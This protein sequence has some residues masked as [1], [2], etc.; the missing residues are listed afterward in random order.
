MAD[1]DLL[2]AL[3]QAVGAEHVLTAVEDRL[4]HS[5]DATFRD[6]LPDLVVS[7]GST[8]EV[9]AV[10]R[11]AAAHRVPLTPRGAASGLSGGAVPLHGGIA[12]SLT[13]L[14]RILAIDVA[15]RRAVV[16][17]GVVTA[18]QAA[19]AWEAGLFYPPDPASAR[20]STVGGNVAECAGGPRGLKYGVTRDYVLALEV[21]LPDGT[22]AEV[23]DPLDGEGC[24]PDWAMLLVGSEGT[25]GIVTRITLRLVGRP[26]A[27]RTA[28]AIFDRLDDAAAAVS[29][30]IAAGV[31]P[32]TLE[33]MDGATLRAVE[34]YL[35]AG[36]PT[37]AEAALLVELDGT[38]G[39][40]EAQ[41]RQ[42][43]EAFRRQGARDVQVAG[44]PADVERLWRARRAI[45]A[46]CGQLNPTKI[47]EDATVPRSRVPAL[48]REVG[49]I[50]RR[51]GV[52]MVVFGHAGDGNLHP[53]VL[54]NRDDPAEMER[55]EAAIGDLFA[56]ALALGGTLSG[57][58]G[59]GCMKAPW[60]ERELGAAGMALG[61]GVKEALDP[62]G[63]LNPGKMFTF[64]AAPVAPPR[65][66][67]QTGWHAA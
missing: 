26:A 9:A 17:P 43:D 19:A 7:P 8:A 45:S 61:R 59:I 24:G 34:A 23:G 56:A 38:P 64:G 52:K 28:L 20:M 48:V 30:T 42:V 55:A 54:T 37:D 47:S 12:L 27:Q 46:A 32:T 22:V 13:R 5:H 50:A 53:N 31:V 14:D 3:R 25:L 6:A 1:R 2:R 4:C 63:L 39:A 58:H 49:E 29:A 33:L 60:L 18:A 40:V 51:H 41:L 21:V 16:E 62:A 67:G 35:H 11:L 15:G 44:S 10:V 57:E 36:L 65:E 66:P